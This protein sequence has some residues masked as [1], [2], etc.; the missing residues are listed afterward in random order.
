MIEARTDSGAGGDERYSDSFQDRYD[1]AL[2]SA[3]EMVTEIADSWNDTS[4]SATE[5]QHRIEES[6]G[7]WNLSD[8]RD[9]E[10]PCRKRHAGPLALRELQTQ[11]RSS[12]ENGGNGLV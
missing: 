8:G 11:I 6:V 7:N 12:V 5:R 9:T 2:A 1:Q 4:H 3:A 10:H